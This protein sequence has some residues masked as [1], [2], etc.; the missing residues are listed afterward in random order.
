MSPQ[1]KKY[2]GLREEFDAAYDDP[3][4]QGQIRQEMKSLWKDLSFEEQGSTDTCP[5]VPM[6]FYDPT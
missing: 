2:L 3:I 5:G 1:Y 6:P 4:L